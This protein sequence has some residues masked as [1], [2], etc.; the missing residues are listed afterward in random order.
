MTESSQKEAVT[1]SA[2]VAT[3]NGDKDKNSKADSEWV[4]LKSRDGFEFI[5]KREEANLSG[6][7]RSS[8]NSVYNFEEAQTG[9]V[10]VDDT[11]EVLDVIVQYLAYK[12]RWNG[13][14]TIPPA[15]DERIPI[16]LAL[17]IA[18]AADFMEL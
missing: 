11:A 3:T 16:E 14:R 13:S 2:T 8:L 9:E 4:T 15:F 17:Q 7:L 10:H 18:Q 1:A 5:I 6:M 12:A